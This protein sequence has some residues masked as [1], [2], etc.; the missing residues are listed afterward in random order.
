MLRCCERLSNRNCELSTILSSI[1]ICETI[2]ATVG[3]RLS[4]SRHA[5][6]GFARLPPK[7]RPLP[8]PPPFNSPPKTSLAF[9][10]PT[11]ISIFLSVGFSSLDCGPRWRQ[12]RGSHKMTPEK[13]N[14]TQGGA[15]P[16][17]T[18]TNPR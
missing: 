9:P 14:R 3:F 10:S 5:L 12:R 16:Q 11:P 4:S 17:A 6:V 15:W 7:Q 13:F 2:A 8:Q 1:S 18:T